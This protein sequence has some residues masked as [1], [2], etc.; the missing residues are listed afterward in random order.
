[1]SDNINQSYNLDAAKTLAQLTALS[2]GIN[3]VGQDLANLNKLTVLAIKI[4]IEDAKAREASVRSLAAA[5]NEM[6]RLARNSKDL[7]LVGKNLKEAFNLDLSSGKLGDL[8]YLKG[9]SETLAKIGQISGLTYAQIRGVF[10]E[11]VQGGEIS[12]TASPKVQQLAAAFQQVNAEALKVANIQGVIERVKELSTSSIKAATVQ[13]GLSATQFNLTKAMRMLEPVYEAIGS[14]QKGNI[15]LSR[16]EIEVKGTLV[17]SMAEIGNKMGENQRQ[18][19]AWANAVRAASMEVKNKQIALAAYIA[20]MKSAHE[21]QKKMDREARARATIGQ[22][23]E[24]LLR[25]NYGFQGK[26]D[27]RTRVELDLIIQSLVKLRESSDLSGRQ[28][29]KLMLDMANNTGKVKPELAGLAKEL[30]GL[31]DR[32]RDFAHLNKYSKEQMIA[33]GQAAREAFV[34]GFPLAAGATENLRNKLTALGNKIGDIAMKSGLQR[35]EFEALVD[36]IQRGDY[37]NKLVKDNVRVAHSVEGVINAQRQLI[38]QQEEMQARSALG[39]GAVDFFRQSMPGPANNLAFIKETDMME[40]QLRKVAETSGLAKIQLQEMITDAT[41]GRQRDY[42]KAQLEINR[43]KILSGTA[44]L[45]E[46]KTLMQTAHHQ[47]T[48]SNNIFRTIQHYRG[49]IQAK[50]LWASEAL[51]SIHLVNVS[52]RSYIRYFVTRSLYR[53]FMSLTSS[54]REGVRAAFDL[55]QRL[56]EIRTITQ[57]SSKSIA[58]WTDELRRLSDVFPQSTLDIAEGAYQ[59][60]SNQVADASNVTG[61]LTQALRLSITTLSTTAESVNALSSVTKSY[62]KDNSKALEV[63]AQLFK[64]VELGR[65]RLADIA[66]EMGNVTVVAA[67]L[68][69]SFAEVGASLTTLTRQGLTPATAMTLLRNVLMKLI[70]PTENMKDLFE[71]WG[72]NG[73]Q[74][75]V[76]TFTFYGVIAKISEK[77]KGDL[78]EINEL[79]SRIRATTG[80]AGLGS[81]ANL[82]Q[83]ARDLEAITASV[84]AYD[85]ATKRAFD[86]TA[87]KLRIE[88]QQLKNYFSVDI[89]NQIIDLLNDVNTSMGGLTPTVKALTGNFLTMVRAVAD[90][91]K[92]FSP[93]L[94]VF[95]P[96]I[97]LYAVLVVQLK[98][99]ATAQALANSAAI[100]YIKTLYAKVAALKATAGA[101]TVAAAATGNWIGL[102]ATAV[103]AIGTYIYISRRME[104]EAFQRTTRAVLASADAWE[105]AQATLEAQEAQLNKV[106]EAEK[107]VADTIRAQLQVSVEARA[108]N[109]KLINGLKDVLKGLTKEWES[110][111]KAMEKATDTTNLTAYINAA[112]SAKDQIKSINAQL[113]ERT[114]D[115]PLLGF[116]GVEEQMAS[117]TNKADAFTRKGNDSYAFALSSVGDV[118][119]ENLQDGRDYLNTALQAM[120]QADQAGT[121]WLRDRTS[122]IAAIQKE[123]SEL[124]KLGT[125]TSLQD[126]QSQAERRKE[127]E[128]E[129]KTLRD[130]EPQVMQ[131]VISLRAQIEESLRTQ[132]SLEQDISKEMDQRAKAEEARIEALKARN[133]ALGESFSALTALDMT[134]LSGASATIQA[135]S[136]ELPSMLKELASRGPEGLQAANALRQTFQE[137]SKTFL[138]AQQNAELDQRDKVATAIGDHLTSSINNL[139]GTLEKA[140]DSLGRVADTAFR[141]FREFRSNIASEQFKRG[142]GYSEKDTIGN[143]ARISMGLPVQLEEAPWMT[144]RKAILAE[145]AQ[146]EAD[147][148]KYV[149]KTGVVARPNDPE[150]MARTQRIGE[151]MAELTQISA[152]SEI[153]GR[154]ETQLRRGEEVAKAIAASESGAAALQNL[155]N[156]QDTALKS[157]KDTALSISQLNEIYKELTGSDAV[158]LKAFEESIGRIDPALRGM[159]DNLHT[160]GPNAVSVGLTNP[161]II[162]RGQVAQTQAEVNAL[163]LSIQ[164]AGAAKAAAGV[165]AQGFAS[166]GWVRGTGTGDSVPAMLTPGEFVVNRQ[167][168]ATFAP[169]LEA[170]NNGRG[171]SST[172]QTQNNTYGNVTINIQGN[173][174]TGNVTPETARQVADLIYRE[175]RR[176]RVR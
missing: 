147:Y 83:F 55:Q 117:L 96:L 21:E 9:Y 82:A 27:T 3:A 141:D 101:A 88:M 105:A 2:K 102:I 176:G 36:A 68:G 118:L 12:A 166:G 94:R 26:V 78:T 138:A 121:Q 33:V 139:S 107:R 170:L 111:F 149:S 19:A 175:Q 89:G 158:N 116:S 29:N 157:L 99:Y 75:A 65:M 15:Q 8:S 130:G 133:E 136:A 106:Q 97:G 53:A 171:T 167:S 85:E 38:K 81:E 6:K 32:F 30:I 71:E 169:M 18:Q 113:F 142:E 79:F 60:L 132:L 44:N 98:L 120:Q 28:F 72:V 49:L 20:A 135:V 129:L 64:V 40:Q 103:A 10:K 87:M 159:L 1:M 25:N 152:Q 35:K 62:N 61:F 31:T 67:Q 174:P 90:I 13:E 122:R 145:A 168:A 58:T 150:F 155:I 140:K 7:T 50:K 108:A 16:A 154:L 95:K 165:A 56:A 144:Q 172:S 162:F 146:L 137:V 93:V 46:Q 125:V 70:G 47:Q 52:W 148:Q 119:A 164:R 45:E 123:L 92:F 143:A 51:K 48:V 104:R 43:A 76:D 84:E 110:A 161:M 109:F 112:K 37:A 80:F 69:I 54:M 63:S 34:T 5:S 24:K 124:G 11:I 42:V 126:M 100:G 173:N 57:N 17:R 74:A 153:R 22:N 91:V 127:L 86:N 115:E 23:T 41:L 156:Q 14:K 128:K 131:T 134:D 151:L 114:F 77:T 4:D 66:D 39:Q 163:I 59:A 73:A 160:E